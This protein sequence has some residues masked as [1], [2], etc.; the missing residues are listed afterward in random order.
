M[1]CIAQPQP[2]QPRLRQDDRVEVLL[3]QLAQPRSHV[4]ADRRQLQVRPAVQCL[5]PPPQAAVATTAPCGRSSNRAWRRDTKTSPV[6]PRSGTAP[7]V[8]PV[9]VGGRQVFQAMHGHIDGVRQQGALNLLG[10]HAVAAD[11]RQRQVAHHVAG[12]FDQDQLDGPRRGQRPQPSGDVIGLP[13]GQRTAARADAQRRNHKVGAP[14]SCSRRRI[15]S[16]VA[17]RSRGPVSIRRR[18]S[19][20]R[21]A[22]SRASQTGFRTSGSL[23]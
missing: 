8:S 19:A 14:R 6:G 16:A 18:C 21:S 5:R 4:A 12:R 17:A 23:A 13:E 1:I 15:S 3:V 2:F 20:S 11:L 22:R 10:E 9:N 7:S